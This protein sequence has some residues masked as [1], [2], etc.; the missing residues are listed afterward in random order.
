MPIAYRNRCTLP[1]F[2]TVPLGYISIFLHGV[3]LASK[4]ELHSS[5]AQV[6]PKVIAQ[7]EDL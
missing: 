6:L 7:V 5:R 3:H 2:E 1:G 4:H